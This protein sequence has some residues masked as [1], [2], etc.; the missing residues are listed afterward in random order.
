MVVRNIMEKNTRM[1]RG[2]RSERVGKLSD[3]PPDYAVKKE[4]N[5]YG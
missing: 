1:D 5:K 4:M 3:D 2:I